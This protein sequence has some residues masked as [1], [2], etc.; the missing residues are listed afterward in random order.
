MLLHTIFFFSLFTAVVVGGGINRCEGE[1]PG[2]AMNR[3]A[4]AVVLTVVI[5]L[6]CAI[7]V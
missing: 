5:G 1:G 4:E 3:Q 7:L 6:K 2:S